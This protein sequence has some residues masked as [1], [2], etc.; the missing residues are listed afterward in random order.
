[1]T[2]SDGEGFG[3][4]ISPA[5]PDRNRAG[6][7]H[8]RLDA[9]GLKRGWSARVAVLA[10]LVA[11]G[12][13]WAQPDASEHVTE[14]LPV[15]SR[16][17]AIGSEMPEMILIAGGTFAMGSSTGDPDECPVHDV[18]VATF[19]ISRT[20]VTVRQ[21]EQCVESKHCTEPMTGSTCNW[22]VA[23]RGDHPVNCLSW[24]Q[25][26]EY[27]AWMGGRLPSEAEWEYAAR[28]RGLDQEYPW[29]DEPADCERAVMRDESGRGCGEKRTWPVC[30]K[31]LGNTEQGLCD[32]AGNV[33][34]RVEDDWHHTYEGAPVDGEPWIDRPR[35]GSGRVVRGGSWRLE[36]WSLRVA[37]RDRTLPSG[38]L[39]VPAL[40]FRV[41]RS[42]SQ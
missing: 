15:D 32:M 10:V 42:I 13:L 17:P 39:P 41:A 18:T 23:G 29:G 22:R 36:P 24:Y 34:E 35:R 31:P 8:E 9:I 4:F 5:S 14:T 28:S 21:Y 6:V 19:E 40:G 25:A 2:A 26:R 27:A 1:M 12:P 37:S 11:S 7:L 20:E 16:A 38:P 3:F 30:S 33:T